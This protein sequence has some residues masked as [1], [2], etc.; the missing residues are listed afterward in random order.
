MSLFNWHVQQSLIKYL[1]Q[2][3]RGLRPTKD[4]SKCIILDNV[5][6]HLEFD[7]PDSDRQWEEEFIGEPKQRKKRTSSS[8]TRESVPNERSFSEGVEE[9]GLIEDVDIPQKSDDIEVSESNWKEED[10]TLLKTLYIERNCP[11]DLIASVFHLDV[12]HISKRL[13]DLGLTK[14]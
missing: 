10:D 4:K 8:I 6:A 13:N 12:S 11:L 3:G 1:Q 9:L 7:L 14:E 2:V 5:G